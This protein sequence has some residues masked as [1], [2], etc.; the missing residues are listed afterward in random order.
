MTPNFLVIGA[1]KCG[2][3]SLC[4]LLAQ[5]PGVF[6][7]PEKEIHFFSKDSLYRRGLAYY[8]QFFEGADDR[9]AIGEGSMTYTQQLDFPR[10]SERVYRHLPEARLIYIARHPLERMIS[11][12]I[13]DVHVKRRSQAPTGFNRAVRR[14]P[15]LLNASRY[16]TQIQLY[17]R[18]FPDERI[19]IL[20]FEEFKTR[21]GEVVKRAF[22]FVGVDPNHRLSSARIARNPNRA[23]TGL[24]RWMRSI[25]HLSQMSR[26]FPEAVKAKLRWSLSRPIP[27]PS[28]EPKAEAWAIAQLKEETQQFLQYAGKAPD[29]WKL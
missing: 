6:I 1:A 15:L 27:R 18:F 28:W 29:Y 8:E 2:S 13:Y 3:T 22:E 11:H 21:P 17:R 19:L 24:L 9:P 12:W 25:S 26:L 20:F 5:H 7:P 4:A 14:Y 23:E 16:W 10:T